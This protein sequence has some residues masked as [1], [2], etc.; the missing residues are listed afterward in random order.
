LAIN[1][2][3]GHLFVC[4]DLYVA[5]YDIRAQNSNPN[6]A[7]IKK[8][9]NYHNDYLCAM[10]LSQ[11]NKLLVTAGEDRS[12]ILWNVAERKKNKISGECS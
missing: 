5:I 6:P 11:D 10:I 8:F 7:P 3:D 4:G 2:N 9:E 1:K 12:I